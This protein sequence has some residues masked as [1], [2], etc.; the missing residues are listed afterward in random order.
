[1]LLD[2]GPSPGVWPIYLASHPFR[3]L[4]DPLE[5]LSFASESSAM[6]LLAQNHFSLTI[7]QKGYFLFLSFVLF[8]IYPW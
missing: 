8:T 5:E 7:V 3:K 2:L 6:G 4:A 1:M